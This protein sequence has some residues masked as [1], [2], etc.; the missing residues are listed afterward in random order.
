M[1]LVIKMKGAELPVN[2]IIIIVLAILVLVAIIT[3]YSGTYSPAR[4]S[5]NLDAV[6][7]N[8]C[9][10]L[11]NRGC[12]VSSGAIP[13]I[14]FDANMNGNNIV[15]GTENYAPSDALVCDGN[16]GDNLAR[17]CACYYG[18]STERQCRESICHC[19]VQ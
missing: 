9:Q 12:Y 17:L 18:V 8:A 3:I 6:K 15:G 13:V 4:G 11:I 1:V 2:T 14:N 7:N 16:G 19:A 5:M 10:D